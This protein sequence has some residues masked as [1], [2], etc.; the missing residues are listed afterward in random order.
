V[1]LLADL[2]DVV[3]TGIRVLHDLDAVPID[4]SLIQERARNIVAV[5]TS[6]YDITAESEIRT[7]IGARARP[8]TP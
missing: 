8:R 5:L 4:E 1:N 2:V 3:A 6:F 7:V